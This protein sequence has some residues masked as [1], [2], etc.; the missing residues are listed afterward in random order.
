MISLSRR[1]GACARVLLGSATAGALALTVAAPAA[2]SP[3]APQAS[4]RPRVTLEFKNAHISSKAHPVVEYGSARLPS[5][6]KLELQ[7]QFGSRRVWRTVM[8]LKGRSGTATAP[9]APQGKYGYRVQADRTRR[10]VATSPTHDLYSYARIPLANICNDSDSTSSVQFSSD[11]QS[12]TVQIGTSVFTWI[13]NDNP[14]APPNYDTDV[15]FGAKTSCRT[16][17]LQWGEDNN[18]ASGDTVGIQIVQSDADPQSSSAG[19]GQ[20]A[21]Y[22]FSLSGGPW[23]MNLSS[24]DDDGEYVNGHLSC[25][26]ASGLG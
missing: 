13:L 16:M 23:D 18:S 12:H 10:L 2:A 22:T 5:G 1:N 21:T 26:S 8:Q 19:F 14:P 17:T 3:T 24:T 15:T 6:S 4:S 7:R 11:C 20:I 9:T 25:W